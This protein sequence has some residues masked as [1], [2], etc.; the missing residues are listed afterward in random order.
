MAITKYGV[1]EKADAEV[2]DE[3]DE[4]EPEQDEQKPESKES[5]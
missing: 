2:L 5:E 3:T 4:Q 1:A